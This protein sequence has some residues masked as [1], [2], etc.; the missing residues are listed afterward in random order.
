MGFTIQEVGFERLLSR[1]LL[2][3]QMEMS[4]VGSCLESMGWVRAGV[5]HWRHQCIDIFTANR[6]DQIMV[7]GMLLEKRGILLAAPGTSQDSESG[8]RRSRKE[9]NKEALA[10]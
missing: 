2:A 1:D 4:G 9:R 10:S 7:K 8:K 5:V 6:F 3:I